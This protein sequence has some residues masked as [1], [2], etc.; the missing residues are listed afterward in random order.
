M[1]SPSSGDT[2]MVFR[3]YYHHANTLLRTAVSLADYLRCDLHSVCDWRIGPTASTKGSEPQRSQ[4]SVRDAAIASPV[5]PS[6]VYRARV[7]MRV[8]SN[9]I[10]L[11]RCAWSRKGS[12]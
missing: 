11:T 12:Q 2:I 4:R 7:H 8:E 10:R 3:T 9:R 1:C 6:K 5:S